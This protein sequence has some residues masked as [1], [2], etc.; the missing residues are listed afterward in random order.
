MFV[1]IHI[2][3]YK[4]FVHKTVTSDVHGHYKSNNV[5]WNSKALTILHQINR[6]F[7][8]HGKYTMTLLSC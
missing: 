8:D 5:Q 3:S 2:L 4:L 1:N 6:V 7:A